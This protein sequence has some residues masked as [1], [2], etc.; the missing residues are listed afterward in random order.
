VHTAFFWLVNTVRSRY[1]ERLYRQLQAQAQAAQQ[2]QYYRLK[3]HLG[4]LTVNTEVHGH[5]G[6]TVVIT[7]CP[8]VIKTVNIY[9]TLVLCQLQAA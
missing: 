5:S 2:Q 7:V 4:M 6:V 1:F 8:T 3:H 9:V